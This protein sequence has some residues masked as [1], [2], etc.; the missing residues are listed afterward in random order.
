MSQQTTGKDLSQTDIFKLTF[1]VLIAFFG[2]VGNVIVILVVSRLGKRKQP[3][4]FYLQNLAIADLGTLLLAFPAIVIKEQDAPNWPLGEFACHYIYP[5]PEMFFGASV[6]F[7]AVISVER[8]RKVVAAKPQTSRK[9]KVL[10]RRAKVFATCVWGA[11][12]FV[13]S[14]PLYFIVAYEE[15]RK[16][17]KMVWPSWDDGMVLLRL[18]LVLLTLFSYI[19]PLIVISFTYLAITRTINQSTEILKAMRQEQTMEDNRG[20]ISLAKVESVRINHNRR[21]KKILTPL[22]LVFA[23]TMLPLSIL[24]LTLVLWLELSTQDYYG[25]LLYIISVFVIFNSSVNP[26]IYSVV[27]REF[28]KGMNNLCI[29][30]FNKSSSYN[31]AEGVRSRRRSARRN[32]AAITCGCGND[33][34][35]NQ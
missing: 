2:V 5:V 35:T 28:R 9:H 34:S 30:R 20:R 17:C 21:A 32:T 1:E 33:N 4:D 8:Y 27:S 24:R 14:F 23:A 19:L 22:V 31:L 3:G 29:R 15:E 25:N 10:L 18:Y 12:F 13:F 16:S 11:S 6:W 26:V 7:I